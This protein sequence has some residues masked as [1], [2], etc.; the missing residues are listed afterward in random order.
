MNKGVKWVIVHTGCPED[1]QSEPYDTRE[2]AERARAELDQ[3]PGCGTETTEVN[4][5]V[6]DVPID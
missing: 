3:C 2:E 6:Q 1:W 5:T 4:Y